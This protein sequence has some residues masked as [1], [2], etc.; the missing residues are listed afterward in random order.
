MVE[1]GRYPYGEQG[2]RALD[3]DALISNEQACMISMNA[4]RQTKLEGLRPD[5]EEVAIWGPS[6]PWGW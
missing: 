5:G 6:S 2:T 1:D 4:V 3:G